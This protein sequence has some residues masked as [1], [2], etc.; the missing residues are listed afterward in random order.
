MLVRSHHRIEARDPIL[1]SSSCCEYDCDHI[2]H[3][4][5]LS[6]G[7][8]C[9]FF[10][11]HLRAFCRLSFNIKI[12]SSFDLSR[13][14]MT[15]LRKSKSMSLTSSKRGMFSES[16]LNW[17]LYWPLPLISWRENWCAQILFEQKLKGLYTEFP[18][19]IYGSIEGS[20][21]LSIPIF[22]LTF[23]VINLIIL[24]L[25]LPST[26]LCEDSTMAHE[27]KTLQIEIWILTSSKRSSFSEIFLKWYL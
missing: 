24:A 15:H 19:S 6:W 22:W 7:F 12:Y 17:Y 21:G 9:E 23:Q 3:I 2:I 4:N 26:N 27:S 8:W 16:F 13:D 18:W 20:S 1:T 5:Y 14:F 25:L 10:W 11:S